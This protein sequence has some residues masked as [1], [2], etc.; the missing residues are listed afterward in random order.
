MCLILFFFVYLKSFYLIC[1]KEDDIL[2][3]YFEFDLLL[4]FWILLDNED[5]LKVV[6]YVFKVRK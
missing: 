4:F 1:Y 2:E 3:G 6:N 5:L